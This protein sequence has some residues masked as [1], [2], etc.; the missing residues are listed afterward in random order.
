MLDFSYGTSSAI[1]F[2]SQKNKLKLLRAALSN[3]QTQPVS[4]NS[5]CHKPSWFPWPDEKTYYPASTAK[6][7][8]VYVLCWGL[9]MSYIW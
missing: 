8:Y 2:T 3:E 7:L 6:T 5:S 9:S 4:F 1:W